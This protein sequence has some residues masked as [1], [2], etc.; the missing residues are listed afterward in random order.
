MREETHQVRRLVIELT[1]PRAEDAARLQERFGRLCR[2]RVVPLLDRCCSARCGPERLVRIE[3]LEIDLGL[4][5]PESPDD[6]LVARIGVELDRRL[7]ELIGPAQ[8][9]ADRPEG[10]PRAG[11]H[12]ELFEHFARNGHLPW[13][14]DTTRPRPLDDAL[15]HLL[16]HAPESLAKSLIVLLQGDRPLRR[17]IHHFDDD[18]LSRLAG[19]LA[20]PR[21]PAST[22][23]PRELL[24][25]LREAASPFD[26]GRNLRGAFWRAALVATASNP[27]VRRDPS[28]FCVQVLPRVAAELRIDTATLLAALRRAA[29][30]VGR[31]LR[32]PLVEAI[33]TLSR[34][35]DR[36]RHGEG[37]AAEALAEILER[38][39]RRGGPWVGLFETLASVAGRL[40]AAIQ[41]RWLAT[42]RGLERKAADGGPAVT[43]ALPDLIRPCLDDARRHAPELSPALAANVKAPAAA[44]ETLSREA[45][46]SRHGEWEAAEA[47]AEILER[48]QRRGGPWVGLFETLASVAGRLPAAIQARWLATLRGLER[49]AADGGPAVTDA[50]PDLIRPCLDDARRHAPE[51]SPALAANVKAP[52]A[53][54]IPAGRG[55]GDADEIDVGNAG[56]VI[57]WPFL[58]PFF[59]RLGLLDDDRFRDPAAM[60]RAV[61]LLGY[62]A[63][64]D[65]DPAEYWLPL[66]KVLCGMD[67]DEVFDFGPPVTEAEAEECS[68]LLR[69]VIGH[70]AI[71]NDMSVDG[72][73]GSFLIRQG[74]LGTRDG[75]WLLRVEGQTY[76]IVLERFP[77]TWAWVKLPWMEAPLRAEW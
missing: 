24:G 72:F 58:R 64:A 55:S 75:S 14:A 22:P 1:I 71:L 73:R 59:G 19:L 67:L 50:L 74:L 3:S 68:S 76:D 29:A 21:D 17:I 69:A 6:D 47:L 10:G 12:L 39:Q 53:K 35:A 40:P 48:W 18:A 16:R 13:W 70:A 32:A 56:L 31:T 49:E 34:Q 44:V 51:L 20:V 9:E 60:H 62:L 11:S 54:S 2:N 36:S 7:G 5:S 43:D 52:A 27:E 38:W 77:W 30:T 37:E 4:L 15:D 42:L 23:L 46:R 8:D 65:P 66:A 33:E 28:A 41:A 63:H 61:G 57:L 26:L 45:D 25:I